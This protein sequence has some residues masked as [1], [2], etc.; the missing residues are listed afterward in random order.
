MKKIWMPIFVAALSLS[1]CSNDAPE[2]T[3]EERVTPVETATVIQGD[4]EV[5]KQFYGRISP[6]SMTPIMSPAPG[7]V[8]ALHVENGE[9]VEEGEII[10]SIQTSE[11]PAPLEIEATQN[12]QVA[13]VTVQEG[14]IASNSEPMMTIVDLDSM[15]VAIEVTAS[16]LALFEN[17]EEA[18]VTIENVNY[19]EEVAISHVA[20][21]PGDTGLYTV[22][23]IVEN[24]DE[25]IKP[26]MSAV[27]TIA[28]RVVEEAFILP[29]AALVEENETTFVYLVEEDQAV[30]VPV[31]VIEAQSAQVAVEGELEEEDTVVIRGQLT[32]RDGSPVSVER[33]E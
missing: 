6:E 20:T 11:S 13:N 22:E 19:E 8:E 31:T 3:T 21:V 16:N 30:E 4:L 17:T 27:V 28:E 23:L 5:T 18:I 1:A 9:Q 7:E 15:I 12:G 10:A 24:E 29:T 25:E 2:E 14:G 32:L 33:E 26:G